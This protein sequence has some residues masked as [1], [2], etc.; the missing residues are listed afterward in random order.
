MLAGD[1]HCPPQLSFLPPQLPLQVPLPITLSHTSAVP[2]PCPPPQLSLLPAPL[3]VPHLSCPF[4][5]RPS[6]SPT[7]AVPSPHAPTRPPPQLFLLAVEPGVF[8]PLLPVDVVLPPAHRLHL[9]VL[10]SLLSSETRRSLIEP[11]PLTLHLQHD[12]SQSAPAADGSQSVPVV[13]D[14]GSE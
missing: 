10:P 8:F 14:G 3:P 11:L 12:G 2:S 13:D 6:P 7:S 4:S 1:I 5:P 9:V